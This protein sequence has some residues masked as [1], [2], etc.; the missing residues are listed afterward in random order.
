MKHKNRKLEGKVALVTGASS[1]IGKET[2]NLLLKSGARV[3]AAARRVEKMQELEDNGAVAIKMDVTSEQDMQQHIAD[4]LKK[5]GAIDILINNAGYGSYGAIEDVPLAE[6]RQQFEVNLFGLARLTQLVLPAMRAS[7]Y[8]KIVNISSI[9][10]KIYTPYGGWYHAA[11]HALEGFSD[12]LRLE[13][14]PFGIDVIIIEPGGIATEWG[15]IAAEHLE[16]RSAAG[17][18]AENALKV[19]KGMKHLYASGKLTPPETIARLIIQA[20]TVQ[21]PKT[22]YAKGSM[23]WLALSARNIFSDRLFDRVIKRMLA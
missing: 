14:K 2:V 21:K 13:A 16:K 4:I 20:V 11:K 6:A 1:G 10:G 15:T 5:E 3:Y 22:R 12:C 19:A 18:Y 7:H 23:A 8:G 17:P 9:A